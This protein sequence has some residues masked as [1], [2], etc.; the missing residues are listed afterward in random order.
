M[1]TKT[2]ILRVI[3]IYCLECCGNDIKEINN[4]IVNKCSLY[5]FRLG[6]DPNPGK[7]KNPNPT[8]GRV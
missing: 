5:P 8:F 6:K 2:D 3:K 1:T 7:N 4:C